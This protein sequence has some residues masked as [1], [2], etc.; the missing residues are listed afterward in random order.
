MPVTPAMRV[1]VAEDQALVAML[2]EDELVR[3]GFAIV[4]PFATCAEATGW[5][6]ADTPDLA[7]LDFELRDGPCTDVAR[8]LNRRGVPFVVLSGGRQ[9][10]LPEPFRRAPWLA[11]PNSMEELPAILRSL[12]PHGMVAGGGSCDGPS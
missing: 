4:G 11:K 8:E 7:V 10:A 5:L 9:E 2:A 12:A 1:L 3:A 6:A